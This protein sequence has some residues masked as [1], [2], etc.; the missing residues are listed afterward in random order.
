MDCP[1]NRAERGSYPLA[2]RWMCSA[3]CRSATGWN[4]AAGFHAAPSSP[5][6]QQKMLA[7]IT[8]WP[9]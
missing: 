1:D 4:L 7:C 8:D 6:E 5:E 3:R 9:A 2:D